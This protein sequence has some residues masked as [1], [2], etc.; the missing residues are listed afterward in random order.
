MGSELTDSEKIYGMEKDITNIRSDIKYLYTA[1]EKAFKRLD[2]IKE[3]EIRGV[4]ILVS[5]DEI[6]NQYPGERSHAQTDTIIRSAM[7]EIRCLRE[8]LLVLE[9]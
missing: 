6:L 9:V 5:L 1:V 8:R 4:D 3:P 2:G 7:E